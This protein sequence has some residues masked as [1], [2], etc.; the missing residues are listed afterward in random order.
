MKRLKQSIFAIALLTLMVACG[1][2]TI[3]EQ[4]KHVDTLEVYKATLEVNKALVNDFVEAM[5][6][7]NT[8]KLK[9]MITPDFSWWIIGKPEYL[10]TGGEHNT[11]Y[12][13]GF[14]KKSFIP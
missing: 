9:T 6:T 8:D 13:L 4:V 1:E 5:K 7:S 2:K 14:F 3:T 11:E 10:A 12:F